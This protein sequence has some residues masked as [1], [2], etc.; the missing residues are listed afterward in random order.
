MTV[1]A[2]LT[3]GQPLESLEVPTLSATTHASVSLAGGEGLLPSK[4]CALMALS[5]L[6]YCSLSVQ[7]LR[8]DFFL[9]PDCFSSCSPNLKTVCDLCGTKGGTGL[10]QQNHLNPN[11]AV[12]GPSMGP[13][14]E[15]AGHCFPSFVP[16]AQVAS[17][18]SVPLC[19]R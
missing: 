10:A 4:A 3:K 1:R 16:A 17:V 19:H 8:Y 12:V 11:L 13:G 6:R 7:F 2:I 5:L 9:T 18:Q 15:G 14:G